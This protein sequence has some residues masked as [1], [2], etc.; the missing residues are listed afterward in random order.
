[1][2][3]NEEK[4]KNNNESNDAVIAALQDIVEQ[5]KTLNSAIMVLTVIQP[6]MTE[7]EKLKEKV[8]YLRKNL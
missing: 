1:M 4:V 6:T 5:L 7:P 8:A 2:A 3:V